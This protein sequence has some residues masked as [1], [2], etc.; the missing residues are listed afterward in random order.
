MDILQIIRPKI[1]PLKVSANNLAMRDRLIIV[2]LLVSLIGIVI[3]H[4]IKANAPD[5]SFTLEFAIGDG[6]EYLHQMQLQAK[7]IYY[8]N[9]LQ[10]QLA[11][12][13][14]LIEAV[15]HY[16]TQYH[17]PLVDA[18]PTLITLHNW[19][20]ILALAN[21]ESS[22]CRKYPVSTANCWGVGGSELW[23][24]G[25]NLTEGVVAMNNFLDN[26]PRKN[27]VKYSEMTFE[28]MNGLYKQP[29]KD[30]WVWNNQIIYQD[31]SEI[32][33]ALR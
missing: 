1:Q 14:R 3:P 23:T 13:Q 8:V 11:F 2:L 7:Q 27:A 6:T 4:G 16:L 30:H 24:M 5:S 9:M 33:T 17:S 18:V 26:Y 15:Q 19:K 21:A 25:G 28:Q 32:E 31:L 29:P 22:L 20:Q 10:D 12:K